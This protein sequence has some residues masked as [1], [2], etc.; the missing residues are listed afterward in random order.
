MSITHNINKRKTKERLKSKKALEEFLKRGGK[1][2]EIPEGETT[3]AAHMKFKY[4][5]TKKDIKKLPVE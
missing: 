3:D 2:T 1:I 5:K 4:R